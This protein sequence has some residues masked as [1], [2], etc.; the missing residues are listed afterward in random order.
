MFKKEVLAS[1]SSFMKEGRRD[2]ESNNLSKIDAL[3]IEETERK[4]EEDKKKISSIASMI[5]ILENK[6]KIFESLDR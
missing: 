3:S 2:S 5:D 1:V 4:I 6:R